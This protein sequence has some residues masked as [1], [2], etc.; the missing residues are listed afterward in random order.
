MENLRKNLNKI[1]NVSIFK[2]TLLLILF[3]CLILIVINQQNIQFLFNGFQNVTQ[4]D[5]Q[6]YFLDVGQASATLVIFPNDQ[7]LLID[8]GSTDSA[9]DFVS[10]VKFLLNRN[11]LKDIDL[12]ILTHSDADHVGGAVSV[13]ESFQVNNVY[14]PKILSA[15]EKND[16]DYSISTT[17]TYK[18]VINAISS[19]P[20]CQISFVEDKQFFENDYSLE[21]FA[22]NEERYSDT[23]S[24]S[25]Y[26]V[27][28]ISNRTF[29]FTGDATQE[30]ETEFLTE[31]SMQ[32]RTLCVDFFQVAHHGSKYS[33]TP[34]FLQAISPKFAFV[35]A[36][37]SS[38][39]SH[40]VLKRLQNVQVQDVYVTKTDGMIGVG[41]SVGGHFVI[42]T[43]DVFVDIPLFVVIFTCA[44][45]V[46]LKFVYKSPKI[47][48]AN[49]SLKNFVI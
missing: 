29:L 31:L 16:F 24:Y 15:D 39:P 4:S 46:L 19:E 13:F 34:E 7:T 21:I 37:D 14:R 9:N 22:A 27:L 11:N 20:D 12:L 10:D 42:C 3:C 47:A 40:E 43:L 49:N 32:S 28:T 25:P 6:V 48:F 23:N 5:L 18:N 38:H 41:V 26:I 44:L 8:T 45:F 30:R 35:S 1:K 17:L 36:G 33:S 2:A